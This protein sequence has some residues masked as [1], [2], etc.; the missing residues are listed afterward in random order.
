MCAAGDT[1]PPPQPVQRGRWPAVGS[2]SLSWHRR[3]TGPPRT[4][5]RGAQDH[6]EHQGTGVR[7]RAAPAPQHQ[8]QDHAEHQSTSV[9]TRAAPAPQHQRQGHPEHQSTS[10]RAAPAPEHQRQEHLHGSSGSGG[11]GNSAPAAT[12]RT[13][14]MTPTLFDT[15][16]LLHF[17]RVCI[18]L[19]SLP[20]SQLVQVDRFILS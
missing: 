19:F 9:R 7:T 8:R 17:G 5:R 6:A 13:L 15:L 12:S 11:S 10:V 14:L 1:C 3:P 20:I 2:D 4:D 18:V 16:P